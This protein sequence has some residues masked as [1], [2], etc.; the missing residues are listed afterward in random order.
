MDCEIQKIAQL[1]NPAQLDLSAEIVKHTESRMAQLV[2]ENAVLRDDIADLLRE[3]ARLVR[4]I[5]GSQESGKQG[6]WTIAGTQASTDIPGELDCLQ[7]ALGSLGWAQFDAGVLRL[8]RLQRSI[9]HMLGRESAGP[10]H[11]LEDIAAF[12]RVE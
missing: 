7:H 12:C 1:L 3:K 9:D 4:G 11:S 2:F 10:V 6:G 5:Q 8:F